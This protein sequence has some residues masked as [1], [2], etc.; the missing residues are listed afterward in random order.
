MPIFTSSGE[1]ITYDKNHL[2]PAGA[3]FLG[4]VLFSKTK[5]AAIFN[6]ELIADR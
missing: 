5:L 3:R 2:T 4:D 6:R 1:F